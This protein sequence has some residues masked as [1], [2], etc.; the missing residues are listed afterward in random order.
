MTNTL[1]YYDMELIVTV[2]KFER[3]GTS[4]TM[5]IRFFRETNFA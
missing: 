5:F 3:T 2:N 1:A 4:T